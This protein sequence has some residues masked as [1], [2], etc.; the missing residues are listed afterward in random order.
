MSSGE[1]ELPE[2]GRER[3]NWRFLF[4]PRWLGWHLLAWVLIFGMLALGY[5]Q[6]RRAMGGNAL[7]WAYTFEWPVFA[8]FGVVFWAKTIRDEF[9]PPDTDTVADRVRLAVGNYASPEARGKEMVLLRESH[10]YFD[11]ED[12]DPDEEEALIAYNDYLARLSGDPR[13]AR[14]RGR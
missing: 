1:A 10:L 5:W 6:Y 3:R 4:T 11:D 12:M 13:A 9:A 2:A 7:S 8:I 14:R